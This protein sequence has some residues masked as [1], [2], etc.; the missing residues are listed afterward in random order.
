MS[1]DA[2]HFRFQSGSDLDLRDVPTSI[3]RATAGFKGIKLK[4]VLL[5]KVRQIQKW[6]ENLFAE[7]QQSLLVILQGMD[8]SGKDSTIK[9]VCTGVNPQGLRV[10][11]F[12]VPTATEFERSF[13]HRF[14]D[15]FPSRGFIHVFNRSYYEEVTVVRVHPHLLELRKL[16]PETV[17]KKYWQH[18]IDDIN[19]LE[20]HLQA[21]GTHI[22]KIFLHISKKE[23]IKRLAARL[24]NPEKYWKFDPSDIKEREFWAEYQEVYS[25]A[26]SKS[27]TETSPWYVFPADH[28]PT[29]RVLVADAIERELATM[30]PSTPELTPEQTEMITHYRKLTRRQTA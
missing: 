7:N 9:H 5:Q 4:T 27:A 26:M 15:K 6:Q 23:Q 19:A 17:N 30:S 12:S 8:T 21:N 11:S 10:Y 13:L 3:D 25:W 28:K 24:N 14:W 16:R 20:A 22:L 29:A 18:R 2:E 1:L